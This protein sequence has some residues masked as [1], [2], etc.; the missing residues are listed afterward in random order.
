M[1]GIELRTEQQPEDEEEYDE[2]EEEEEEEMKIKGKANHCSSLYF[3][4]I[5]CLGFRTPIKL[6]SPHILPISHIFLFFL[7]TARGTIYP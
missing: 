1:K 5:S 7:F 2:E 6:I 4:L 3:V